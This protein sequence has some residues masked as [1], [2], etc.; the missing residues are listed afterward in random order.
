MSACVSLLKKGQFICSLANNLALSEVL[1]KE[2]DYFKFKRRYGFI[3]Y[4]LG[5]GLEIW[6]KDMRSQAKKTEKFESF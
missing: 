1:K 3:M 6:M 5:L 4:F 2:M